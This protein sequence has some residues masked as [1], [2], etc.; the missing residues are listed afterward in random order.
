MRRVL[1]RVA[2]AAA[3]LLAALAAAHAGP[4]DLATLDACVD[5]APPGP[6]EMLRLFC[7]TREAHRTGDRAGVILWLERRVAAAPADH[8]A[9]LALAQLHHELADGRNEA[10]L[11]DALR[12]FEDSADARGQVVVRLALAQL[13]SL[14]QRADEAAALLEAARATAQHAGEPDLAWRVTVVDAYRRLYA[15][16]YGGT[17]TL[18]REVESAVFPHGPIE[19][20][21]LVLR[22]LGG[23]AYGV[24]RNADA[25][26]YYRRQEE[27][28]RPLDDPYLR[29]AIL[30]NVSLARAR[31]APPWNAEGRAL[32]A[33][34]LDA[35]RRGHNARVEADLLL[36]YAQDMELPTAARIEN[37]RRAIALTR[38]LKDAP[39]LCFALRLLA[40]TTSELGPAH[41]A[42]AYGYVDEA[43]AEARRI[44]NA[45]HLARGLLVRT[46]TDWEYGDR[47]AAN[48]DAERAF[49]AIEA[50]RDL[51]PDAS[52]RA[53]VFAQ[54]VFFYQ[55]AAGF[56]LGGN[57]T[58][59]APDV[60]RAFRIMERYRARVL[61]DQLDATRGLV[62]SAVPEAAERDRVLEQIAAVQRR[63]FEGNLGDGEDAALAELAALRDR[64]AALRDA[65]ARKD[66]RFAAVR[67][68]ALP[69]VDEVR[70]A[71]GPDV[72]LLSFSVP[73]GAAYKWGNWLTVVSRGGA[74]VYRLPE[75]DAI[76]T[77]VA[78]FTAVLAR[79][80]G[81]EA[82]GAA[83]LYR[84]LLER[85]L[86][87]LGPGV[88]KLVVVPDEPL[89]RLPF[90]ALLEAGAGA[91]RAP[92]GAHYELQIV[93]SASVWLRLRAR[94]A[95]G[96]PSVLALA[97]PELPHEGPPSAVRAGS[98]TPRAARLGR[99]ARSRDEARAAA[100][101]FGGASRLLFGADASEAALKGAPLGRYGVVHLAAHA[102]VD[103][104]H[105]ERSSIVLA[106]GAP[107][108]DGLLQ[109]AEIARLD[110]AGRVVVLSGCESSAGTVLPGEGP[111]SL[112]R[113]FFEAGARAVVGS[114]WPLRDDEAAELLAAFYRRL[115]R[116]A[117]LATALAEA[118]R[119]RLAAGAPPAAWAGL[120]LLGD[121]A[122]VPLPRAQDEPG[123]VPLLGA[124]AVSVLLA[125][126]AFTSMRRRIP[127]R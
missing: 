25:L 124:V 105:P 79:R 106:P 50:L 60:D 95:A 119:E 6:H 111:L 109:P 40:A 92:L 82:A 39:T 41:A 89:H 45:F 55:R 3:V 57:A 127:A 11:R 4:A 69:G 32:L 87:D 19:L 71:L 78:L 125:A 63:L 47:D 123:G 103:P 98:G 34:A 27:V 116:G 62:P 36:S 46:Q 18:L 126:L 115:A 73:S 93:P 66:P 83:Q 24:L 120:V 43:I 17:T 16:D 85:A 59:A 52:V 108:E 100:R 33:E 97:D 13:L 114:L 28:D 72:A 107:Q 75:R 7:W 122:F 77:K 104:V 68:P 99:L 51:Q 10:I 101:S 86:A 38:A 61:L 88:T 1:A 70:A 84:D 48:R 37:E 2:A 81:T 26:Q 49:D 20:R 118:K 121:G 76:E 56:L 53:G 91:A 5:A 21:E 102:V 54:W 31:I 67:R 112:A 96:A 8:A 65:V 23:A 113:P 80:D 9:R 110:F 90:D 94:P 117:S 74:R 44:G 15:Y 14:H 12:A 29:A 42:E 30:Y 58:P 35:A 64:E 22:G